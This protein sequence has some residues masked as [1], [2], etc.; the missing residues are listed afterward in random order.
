[1]LRDRDVGDVRLSDDLRAALR[2]WATVAETVRES[3]DPDEL[4]LVRRR[5]RQ[6]ASRVADVM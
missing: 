4:D 6:L 2:E 1:M 3:G 5:G